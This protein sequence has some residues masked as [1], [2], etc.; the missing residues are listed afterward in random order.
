[1]GPMPTDPRLLIQARD[2]ENR[3]RI[4]WWDSLIVAAAQLQDCATLLTEDLQHGQV[5][6]G[7]RVVNPFLE[8]VDPGLV[9]G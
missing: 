7:V 6:E 9:S 8:D 1:M 5:I 4:S 3:Y 2:V